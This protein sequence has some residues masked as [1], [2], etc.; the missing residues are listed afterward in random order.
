M[1]VTIAMHNMPFWA[2]Q[3]SK[4]VPQGAQFQLGSE[5]AYLSQRGDQAAVPCQRLLPGRLPDHQ[6]LPPQQRRHQAAAPAAC[7]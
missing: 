7:H 5:K 3:A 4:V 2:E 1:G 6:V